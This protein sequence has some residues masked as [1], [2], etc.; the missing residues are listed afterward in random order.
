M[1]EE[2][3]RQAGR[4]AHGVFGDRVL[5]ERLKKANRSL[6][7]TPSAV[8]LSSSENKKGET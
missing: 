7:L 3:V 5:A 2:A 8:L 1:A 6:P 4:D